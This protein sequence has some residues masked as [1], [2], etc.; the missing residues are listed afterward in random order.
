MNDAN[1]QLLALFTAAL[2]YASGAERAAYLN[3]E[4]GQDPAL[5]AEVESLLRAHERAGGF[6]EPPPEHQRP[7]VALDGSSSTLLLGSDPV[8][9]AV[10]AGRY[11][12]V[13]VIGEGG[14]GTVWRAEQTEPVRREVALKVLKPG[15]DS[16]QVLARFEAERQ[17]LALMDHLNIAKVLDAGATEDGHPFF[18]MELIKGTPIT[19]YCDVRMLTPNTRLG[20][21]VQVCHAVQHAHQKGVIHRDLKPSN[22]LVALYDSAP[23]AKVIDF[24][25]AK[26]AGEPLTE[27][28]L[29]TGLGAVVGTPEYMSP[30]QA[31]LNQLDIDTRSDVYSLGVLLY[32]LLTGTTPLAGKRSKETPL[33]DVLRLVREEDP[34]RPS[35]RLTALTDLP[36]IAA[37]RGLEPKRLTR[38]VRG[39]LDWIVMRALEKDRNRRYETAAGFAADVQRY[40]ADEPVLA[41]PPSVGYRLHKFVRRNRGPVLAAAALVTVLAA[42]AVGATAAALREERL[43]VA[44]EQSAA[45]EKAAR[46]ELE[47]TLYFERIALAAQKLAADNRYQV[48][49]LL[50]QCPPHLRGWEWDFLQHW[51]QAEPYVEL[52][53]HTQWIACMAF[54][55][56]G[57]RLA[58]GAADSTVR[59]WDRTTGK[60]AGPPLYGHFGTVMGV[61]FSP[62]GR[63]LAAAGFGDN[64]PKLWD[65]ATGRL[66][67]TLRGHERNVNG[68]AFS[69]DGRL[70]ASPSQDKT[71][72]IWEVET[73]RT[74]HTLLGHE[75]AVFFA[76]FSPDGSRL[77]SMSEDGTVKLWDVSSGRETL[78]WREDSS[79]LTS[80]AFSPDGSRLA[81]AAGPVVQIRDPAD[82]RLERALRGHAG[83]VIGVAFSPDGRRLASASI[84]NTA[85][86]WDPNTG[87]EVLT[88]RGHADFVRG[89]A[90]SPDGRYLA[91][92][93]H[94]QSIRVWDA[95]GRSEG[96][97]GL[98]RTV[99]FNPD[100]NEVTGLYSRCALHPDGRRAAVAYRDGSVRLWDLGNGR[101]VAV[102]RHDLL[103]RTPVFSR[104]GSRLIAADLK[105]DVK[106]WDVATGRELWRGP[107]G[108]TPGWGVPA[109]SPD[110]RWLAFGEARGGTITVRDAATGG[111]L[112]SLRHG[113]DVVWLD[114]SPDGRLLA[115][116]GPNK[117]TR[118]WKTDTFEE[119]HTLEHPNVMISFR[120]SPDSRRL[121]T[122]SNDKTVRVWDLGTGQE[123]FIFRGHSQRV[124]EVDFSPDGRAVGSAG[125]TEALVWNATSGQIMRRYRGH[126]GLVLGARFTPDGKRLVTS[127]DDGTLRVWDAALS[128]L[129]WHGPEAGKLV[130]ERFARL[131]LRADVVDNLRAD[132]AIPG[133]VLPVALQLAEEHDEDPN[134]LDDASRAVVKD[135]GGDPAAY[136]LALRRSEAAC[137]LWPDNGEYLNTLGLAHYRVGQYKEA[138]AALRQAEPLNA[139]WFDGP[140]PPDL[141]LRALLQIQEGRYDEARVTAARLRGLMTSPRQSKG[142]AEAALLHEIDE[143]L[144]QKAGGGPANPKP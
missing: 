68:V 56:D 93:S 129:D 91:T 84:D 22:V 109:I 35:M 128:P 67:H 108:S 88:F 25:V 79:G 4:C 52:R 8:A 130:D 116:C 82:G 92:A 118:V 9:G 36:T 124:T 61:A 38:L 40:L 134:Q 141:A 24:G 143:L 99:R 136:R 16:R 59:I 37:K 139:L 19:A 112:K 135:R 94:D 103:I 20:L 77:A 102:F 104:D 123:I 2:D 72:R 142:S 21:F 144:G 114:F 17:A 18:V 87:R 3:R 140:W 105:G 78:S 47:Y 32:E 122:A 127:G 113:G 115:A 5:R 10:V 27:R 15:M 117:K 62:N 120:F 1:H 75:V 96:A 12:L 132:P 131:L 42:A 69:P 137:R 98:V 29:V 54:H 89:V 53:G 83:K 43:R 138:A 95:T 33:L 23:V 90:F 81:V 73:G 6:L 80:L 125:G 97:G 71:V 26:A 66:L 7:T 58:S 11:T 48:D 60:Q 70:L 133:E 51:L 34:P 76:A 101:E 28:T 14:M 106:I 31:G 119:L 63:L 41:C 57:R 85:K 55:P 100:R 46:G 44:A 39:E 49:E 45:A 13:G 126:A 121:A 74:V 111:A 110:N 30:E 65:V 50:D 86:L 107:G 64:A